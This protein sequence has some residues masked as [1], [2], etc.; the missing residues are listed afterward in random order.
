MITVAMKKTTTP[1]AATVA[2]SVTLLGCSSPA[3]DA[4]ECR[5]SEIHDYCVTT[6]V[7]GLS[8]PW[9]MT[10]LPRGDMLVTEKSGALRLVRDGVLLPDPVPGTPAVESRGQGG[11]LDVVLHP[12]FA[13]N[14]FVYLSYSRPFENES[15]YASMPDYR[16]GRGEIPAST[17]VARARFE[18][19]AL[20]DLEVLWVAK[21]RGNSHFGSRIAFDGNGFMYVTA[22]DRQVAPRGGLDELL[23][24]P[25]QDLSTHHGVIV[26]L[27]DDGRIPADNPF[28]NEEGAL[29]DIYTYGH[30]NPQGLAID[31]ET[32]AV[33]TNEHGPQGG[34][35]VNLVEAGNNYGWP[36]VGYGVNYG[37][38]SSI[39]VGT[40]RDGMTHSHHVWVPSIATSGMLIYTGDAFPGWQGDIFVGGMDGQQVARLTME[41]GEVIAEE[42][43]VRRMGSIRDVRQGPDGMIY[44]AQDNRRDGGSAILRLEPVR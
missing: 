3:L 40:R 44:L 42:T 41:G 19:D 43:L 18:N 15:E 8:R 29:A 1:R 32:G 35:E 13:N 7:E 28:V 33:W 25:A 23:A 38:G 12:D 31:H 9:S 14:G 24:H 5:T 2:L 22:G 4:Q 39:H 26:R 11:L 10:W 20:H 36:V 21:S 30:R 6:V 34:D 16:G 37:S 27:H 17:A